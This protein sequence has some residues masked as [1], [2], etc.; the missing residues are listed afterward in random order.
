MT[1]ED[2]LKARARLG[3]S[4]YDLAQAA[5]LDIKTLATFEEGGRRPRAGTV[6]AVRRAL[7]EAGVI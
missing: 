4:R 3:W 2:C 7:R 6:I 1:A 5:R